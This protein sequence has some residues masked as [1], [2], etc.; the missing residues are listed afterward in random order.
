MKLGLLNRTLT[1]AAL[2]ALAI[3]LGVW[4]TR[5]PLTAAPAPAPP[6]V[7]AIPMKPTPAKHPVPQPTLAPLPLGP[8][9]AATALASTV[10]TEVEVSYE[11]ASPPIPAAPSAPAVAAPLPTPAAQPQSDCQYYHRRGWFRRR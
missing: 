1:A 3:I 5:K 10:T 2:V 8:A 9:V 7:P 6:A 11:I 4:L